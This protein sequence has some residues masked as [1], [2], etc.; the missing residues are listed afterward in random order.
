L[1]AAG[2][3]AGALAATGAPA[4]AA[5]QFVFE[6]PGADTALAKALSNA[7]LTGAALR[8]E[9][10][11]AQDL[12]AA[13]RADYA[14]LLGT[15][16]AQGYYSGVIHILIDGREAASISPLDT[17]ARIGT[18]SI[19]VAPGPRFSF[20][21]AS[22]AP[23][24]PGTV[25]PDGFR[26]GAPA[27]SGT[28][29]AATGAAV[30]G[31]RD[32]GHAK[33]AI[34]AQHIT[35]DHRVAQLAAEVTLS[36]G[37]QLRFG[38]LS[39]AGYQ[40]MNPRRLAE[41]AGF[42]SGE[43]FSPAALAEVRARLRRTG[44]FSAVALTEAERPGADG[45]LD[46]ALMVA[47]E[48]PRRIGFGGDISTLDGLSI[49]GYWLHR[50]LLG[51]GE[52][53]RLEGGVSGIGLGRPDYTLA[54]R[55]DRPATFTPDTSAFARA[56]FAR[57]QEADFSSTALQLG[58]GLSQ[59]FNESLTGE[60]AVSYSVSEVTDASLTQR[61][62]QLAVPVS[63]TWDN[64]DRP[65]DATRGYYLDADATPFL[66]FGSTASGAQFKAEARAYR[67]FG[68]RFVLAGRA[69]L[70]SVQGARL[71][72]TPREYLFY[73]GGGGTVRGQPYQSLG[74]TVLRAGTWVPM[75]GASFAALSAE[76]RA[77]ITD[78]IGIVG[79]YDAGFVSADA[80]FGGG[81]WH[82]GAGLGLRYDTGIGPIRLDVAVPVS[83]G[84]G[85]GVQFYLG[86]G[87]AF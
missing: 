14:R 42:P 19:E 46:V 82:S 39:L 10:A 47:E 22:I 83:G 27:L 20:A 34:A 61:F 32:I 72:D 64:R 17:P 33:A 71:T 5:E 60:A 28:I 62:H 85:S 51:G 58:F 65:L 13:A 84:T 6:T 68:A 53:L 76:L 12:F 8:D 15:L 86:I 18:L 45:T 73:S 49:S 11:T 21:R 44:V 55:L 2:L 23:L 24:A 48:K 7:S 54:A 79:F 59:Y 43:V 37:P 9:R 35:A 41:I 67:A 1:F 31:W 70:G 78:R 3:L 69:Q 29:V 25:L 75:G 57:L 81:A 4:L 38:T 40:R 77:G 36:P 66:G 74:V 56:S 52:R 80:N 50:N 87:Q 16:Y 63:L 30:D 26:I